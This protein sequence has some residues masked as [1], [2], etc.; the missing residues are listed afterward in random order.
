MINIQSSGLFKH[1]V[2]PLKWILRLFTRL[3]VCRQKHKQKREEISFCKIAFETVLIFFR[4]SLPDP[5][6][7]LSRN[8]LLFVY[9]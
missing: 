2:D 6:I 4:H 8:R 5:M 3:I 1:N 9:L 7:M